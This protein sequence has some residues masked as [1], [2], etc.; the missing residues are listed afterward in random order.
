MLAIA[1]LPNLFR[2]MIELFESFIENTLLSMVF[3]FKFS[4]KLLNLIFNSDRKSE[5]QQFS[6]KNWKNAGKKSISGYFSIELLS[7]KNL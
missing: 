5:N 2:E 7:I 1:A 6:Q 3:L 4:I